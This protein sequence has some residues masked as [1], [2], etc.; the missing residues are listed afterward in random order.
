MTKARGKEGQAQVH[1][2][3]TYTH[4]CDCC[5]TWLSKFVEVDFDFEN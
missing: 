2:R 3:T 1:R 4:D 5:E